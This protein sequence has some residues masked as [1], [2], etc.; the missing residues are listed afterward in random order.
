[1]N[2]RVILIIISILILLGCTLSIKHIRQERKEAAR[3][4]LHPLSTTHAQEEAEK[5]PVETWKQWIEKWTEINLGRLV[6]DMPTIDTHQ[7]VEQKRKEICLIKSSATKPRLLRRGCSSGSNIHQK[8]FDNLIK[9][10]HNHRTFSVVGAGMPATLY[11]RE[12]GSSPKQFNH[13]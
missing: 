4:E 12:K 1:M 11:Q 5:L 13:V 7:P 6:Q 9:I 10:W 8:R 3:L 2:H